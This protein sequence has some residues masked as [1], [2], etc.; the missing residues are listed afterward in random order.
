MHSIVALPG[1]VGNNSVIFLLH[2]LYFQRLNISQVPLYDKCEPNGTPR[3]KIDYFSKMKL[4]ISNISS[5]HAHLI[6]ISTNV[7]RKQKFSKFL[8]DSQNIRKL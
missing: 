7:L 1:D 2:Q 6:K 4:G 3:G 5:T 8:S